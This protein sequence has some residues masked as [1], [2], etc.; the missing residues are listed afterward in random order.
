MSATIELDEEPK[1]QIDR[2]LKKDEMYEEF[3]Q[4]LVNHDEAEGRFFREGYSGE[5]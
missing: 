1:E 2:H 3:I 4:D 5:P